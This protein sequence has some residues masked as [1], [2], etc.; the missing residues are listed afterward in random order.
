M[1]IK[2]P[3]PTS[4]TNRTMN[5]K[6]TSHS[7]SHSLPFKRKAPKNPN[8]IRT[9]KYTFWNFIF[10]ALWFEMNKFTNIYFFVTM[11]LQ[12]IPSV[13]TLNPAT[14]IVPFLF[15][16]T[17]ALIREGV[18]DYYRYTKDRK[19]NASP[20]RV[21]DPTR[22]KMT[23]KKWEEISE[24]DLVLLI[25][26]EE[27]P[28]DMVLIYSKSSTSYAYIET[29]NL[30]GEKNLKSKLPL[31]K[32][33]NN[34]DFARPVLQAFQLSYP[35]PTSDIYFFEGFAVDGDQ[36]VYLGKDNF[37]PRGV[38]IK[39]TRYFLGLVVYVGPETKI[40]LNNMSKKNKMSSTEKMMN[41]YVYILVIFEF[42][43]LVVLSI[44]PAVTFKHISRFYS[45]VG[46]KRPNVLSEIFVNFLSYFILL[47]TFLPI[48]LIVTI[49]TVR[50]LQLYFF[51]HDRHFSYPS[52]QTEDASDKQLIP[53]TM[54]LNEELGRIQFLLSDK[55]GTLTQNEMVAKHFCI[56]FNDIMLSKR[57]ATIK[58]LKDDDQKKTVIREFTKDDVVVFPK[59]EQSRGKAIKMGEVGSPEKGN[60]FKGNGSL[61]FDGGVKLYKSSNS[62]LFKGDKR[63]MSREKY[64]DSKSEQILSDAFD[65]I[66]HAGKPHCLYTR[67]R[68]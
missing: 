50:L 3:K 25:E 52:E 57:K 12:S 35:Y 36:K 48:S 26:N 20:A 62:V 40:M 5:I 60:V 4:F 32:Y 33:R 54:T 34:L 61:S 39:N 16:I 59:D 14:V 28:A 23:V 22:N 11:I 19:I 29:S 10:K 45:W 2:P 56:G 47:N 67:A 46:I 55:T 15:I 43:L 7:A 42:I 64:Y 8:R 65:Q 27:T 41:N 17:I 6:N 21:F 13:S 49:E 1:P 53:N 38:F 44:L 51:K 68:G 30:D 58:Q 31:R 66:S 37:V 9:T 18:E 24:G 63:K